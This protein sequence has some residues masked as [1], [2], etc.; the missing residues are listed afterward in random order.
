VIEE[1]ILKVKKLW[2]LKVQIHAFLF[3]HATYLS[4]FFFG[5]KGIDLHNAWPSWLHLMHLMVLS[6]IRAKAFWG[7]W[8][9]FLKSL[10]IFNGNKYMQVYKLS[11]YYRSHPLSAL[12]H[13][14]PQI[15]SCIRLANV[16][17]I[18]YQYNNHTY[19]ILL[20]GNNMDIR[21]E[22]RQSSQVMNWVIEYLAS[23]VEEVHMVQMKA[24]ENLLG[25]L[26]FREWCPK[27][28]QRKQVMFGHSPKKMI[29]EDELVIFF[30]LYMQRVAL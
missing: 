29:Q 12:A 6:S 8:I 17:M 26:Q 21:G 9:Q 10:F 20:K 2:T 5:T 3:E 24:R 14:P 16:H 27:S 19:W 25:L 4:L 1:E 18:T 13:M 30:N 22:E 15:E 28:P 11:T 7:S 23:W